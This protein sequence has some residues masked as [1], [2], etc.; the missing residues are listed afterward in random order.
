VKVRNQLSLFACCKS[1]LWEATAVPT[2]AIVTAAIPTTAV[3]SKSVDGGSG[4]VGS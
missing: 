4:W 1:S 3:P 2:T